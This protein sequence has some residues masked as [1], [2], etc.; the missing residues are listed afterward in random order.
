MASCYTKPLFLRRNRLSDAEGTLYGRIGAKGMFSYFLLLGLINEGY[1]LEISNEGLEG[2]ALAC[3]TSAS[4]LAE[5]IRQSVALGIF[6]KQKYEGFSVLT[7]EE[8]QINHFKTVVGRKPEN[9]E[10]RIPFLISSII[11]SL[12]N[13]A[14][15]KTIFSE[16]LKNIRADFK[17][18]KERLNPK[19]NVLEEIYSRTSNQLRA[20]LQKNILPDK[21]EVTNEELIEKFKKAFPDKVVEEGFQI[22]NFVDMENLI[23][24]INKSPEFLV[25]AK[26]FSLKLCCRPDIYKKIIA[27]FYEKFNHSTTKAS[28]SQNIGRN[29][30]QEEMNA[31]YDKLDEV[32]I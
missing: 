25:S 2:L 32:E 26:N 24:N 22:P 23:E 1:Y 21:N 5:I 8:I 4:G 29:Y 28:K 9:I 6:D 27:G 11:P 14:K 20:L 7:N 18:E 30:T 15:Y 17:Q 10:I 12:L 31:L 13:F 19:N 16:K 3:R